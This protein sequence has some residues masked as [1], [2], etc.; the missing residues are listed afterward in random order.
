MAGT[1][2]SPLPPALLYLNVTATSIKGAMP[3][4]SKATS[5]V[6]ADLSALQLSGTVTES[7]ANH[8]SLFYLDIS[9]NDLTG[10]PTAWTAGS[11][12]VVGAPPL[13]SL[14]L[15][16]NPLNTA[17]PAGLMTYPNL[18]VIVLDNTSLTGA[19]P[20]LP[21]GG[22]PSLLQFYAS[23]NRFTG[24]IPSSWSGALM[25]TPR[26]AS[27]FKYFYMANDSLSGQLPS[28]LGQAYSQIDIYLAGNDFSNACDTQFEVLSLCASS[29]PSGGGGV[30]SPSTSGTASSGSGGSTLSAGAIVGIIIV[31]VVL[32]GSLVAGFIFWRRRR[33]AAGTFERFDDSGAAVE[34]GPQRGTAENNN[35]YNPHLDP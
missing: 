8:P 6:I 17:F 15:Y 35:I 5:I 11:S 2:P 16:N 32:L 4:F 23:N 28:F 22:F 24:S 13:F 3:D 30:L 18:T 26:A 10:L 29:S 14:F 9:G 12:S 20:E 19:L 33:Q 27:A 31:V 34:M 7:V 1:V 25:F 21:K